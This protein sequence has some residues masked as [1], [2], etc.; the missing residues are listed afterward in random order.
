M[1]KTC[2]CFADE[3]KIVTR[4]NDL[5]AT[6]RYKGTFGHN[7]ERLGKD[8][9]RAMK[10]IVGESLI[11]ETRECSPGILKRM[12]IRIR[13]GLGRVLGSEYDP[14]PHSIKVIQNLQKE[15]L[16]ALGEYKHENPEADKPNAYING[17]KM[18]L[19]SL[20]S[21]V[22]GPNITDH[23]IRLFVK[24]GPE[25]VTPDK[26]ADNCVVISYNMS[27]EK[28]LAFIKEHINEATIQNNVR[29]TDKR[30][31]RDRE[32]EMNKY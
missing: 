19:K 8:D 10:D 12:V 22:K 18:Y 32:R 7:L 29:D 25:Q 11:T 1:E 31:Q 16:I 6:A 2:G 20:D 5:Y 30:L 24:I 21:K 14:V 4:L 28:N 3:L 15:V 27:F 23:K 9:L 26:E 17:F 13:K